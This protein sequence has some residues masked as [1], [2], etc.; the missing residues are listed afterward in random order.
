MTGPAVHG[1]FADLFGD[2]ELAAQFTPFALTAD[3]LAVEAALSRA[4]GHAGLLSQDVAEAAARAIE[5]AA[6]DAEALAL[7]T[8]RDGLPVPA[9]V[10]ELKRQISPELHPAVHPHSTS[11]DILDTALMRALARCNRVILARAA[12]LD[13]D[14]EALDAHHGT[15]PLMARTRM[16]AALPVTASH[17]IAQWRAPLGAA[18]ARLAA[19]RPDLERVQLGGPVGDRR[20]YGAQGDAVERHMADALGLHPAGACWHTDR[21][22]VM[23]YGSGLATLAAALGKLGQDVALMAQQGV[24][25]IKIAGG[26]ASS[27]MP[28][29]ANPIGAETLVTLARLTA[30]HLGTLQ[31]AM[32]HEQE[33]SGSAWMLEWL[34]LPQLVTATGAA[35]RTATALV[36]SIERVGDRP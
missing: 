28:H 30:G 5:G 13:E 17:R 1:T 4:V 25:E 35:L 33:R 31:G 16:Q 3:M 7:G 11:Q 24:G 29:K 22:A 27:A 23:T 36:A 10:A 8:L 26:G 19:L 21:S 6:P 15:A 32:V 2:A 12:S 9:L 20:G 18:A 14:L 34:V